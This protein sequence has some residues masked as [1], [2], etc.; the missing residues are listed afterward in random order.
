MGYEYVTHLLIF[1]LV[2]LT[3]NSVMY[4][5]IAHNSSI[6]FTLHDNNIFN[7][8]ASFLSWVL[9]LVLLSSSKVTLA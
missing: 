6:T 3:G 2:W 9:S 8:A 5:E 7:V 4:C 1:L